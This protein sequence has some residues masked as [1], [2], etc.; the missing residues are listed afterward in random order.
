M[1]SETFKR[2]MALV[3][4]WPKGDDLMGSTEKAQLHDQIEASNRASHW[5]QPH[6]RSLS[7]NQ[8]FH[9]MAQFDRVTGPKEILG[10]PFRT[11][12]EISSYEECAIGT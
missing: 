6:L 1:A 3:I 10:Q 12:R 8:S 2:C 5:S 9:L 11:E 4:L 7:T